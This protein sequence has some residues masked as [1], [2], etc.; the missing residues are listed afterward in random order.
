MTYLDEIA[1]AIGDEVGMDMYDESERLLLRIYAVLAL[2][3]GP[4]VTRE[5]VH[6]AWAAWKSHTTTG[7]RSLVP[8]DCLAPEVRALDEPYREAIAKVALRDAMGGAK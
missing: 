4:L 7:H 1:K 6:N 3:K 2:A 8:F 5:D